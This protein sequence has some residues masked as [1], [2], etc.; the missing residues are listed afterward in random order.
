[1]VGIGTA[2]HL[3]LDPVLA[4]L[5]PDAYNDDSIAAGDFRRYTET[6]LRER[7]AAHAAAVTAS[8]ARPVPIVLDEAEAA[9]W[10]GS[11]NDLRLALGTLLDVAEEDDPEERLDEPGGDSYNV[12]LWLTHLQGVLIDALDQPAG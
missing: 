5:F 4:R 7:K 3:P 1:M 10:L 12:Y 9:A 11:L 2:T 6:R 8:L